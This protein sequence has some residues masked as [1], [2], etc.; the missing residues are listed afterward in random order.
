MDAESQLLPLYKIEITAPLYAEGTSLLCWNSNFQP[1]PV[2]KEAGS[3]AIVW[4]SDPYSH[5][6]NQEQ[7]SAVNL[8]VFSNF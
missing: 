2:K 4:S 1:E 5:L 6:T 8:N 7:S 3:E